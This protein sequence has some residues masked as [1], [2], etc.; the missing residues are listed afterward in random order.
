ML[1]SLGKA[2]YFCIII[3]VYLMGCQSKSKEE[4]FAN[5]LDG[6]PRRKDDHLLGAEL[7]LLLNQDFALKI[8]SLCIQKYLEHWANWVHLV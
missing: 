7:L 5:L 2:L 4:R 6:D 3:V 8:V 1:I